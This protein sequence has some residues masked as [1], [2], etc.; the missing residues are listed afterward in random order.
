MGRQRDLNDFGAKSL[1]QLLA[2]TEADA[3]VVT[4]ARVEE[5]EVRKDGGHGGQGGRTRKALV[6]L[7]KEYPANEWVVNVGNTAILFDKLGNDLDRWE[8]ERVP[9]VRVQSTDL[10]DG[11][12]Q[13][14]FH[15]APADA[16]D[17]IFAQFDKPA[18][19]VKRGRK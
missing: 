12:P 9:M 7:T 11:S 5:R 14:K 13:D 17:E 4:I 10:R 1:S 16:W 8:G 6:I 2:E 19:A 15:A 3:A 18:K